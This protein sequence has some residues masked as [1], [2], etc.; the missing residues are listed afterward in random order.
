MTDMVLIQGLW[1]KP[2]VWAE[3]HDEL[4]RL[5]LTASAVDLPV[6]AEATLADQVWSDW[7]STD[8]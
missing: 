5:G 8:S 4:E 2:Q 6:H 3:V 7:L 1:L